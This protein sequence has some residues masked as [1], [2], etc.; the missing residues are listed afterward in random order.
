MNLKS[1]NFFAHFQFQFLEIDFLF[2]GPFIYNEKNII[3]TDDK[4]F[5]LGKMRFHFVSKNTISLIRITF[6]HFQKPITH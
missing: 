4:S 3:K 6:V 1:E 5:S 2:S